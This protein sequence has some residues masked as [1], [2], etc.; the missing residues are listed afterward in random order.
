MKQLATEDSERSTAVRGLYG[1]ADN[2]RR[3][4]HQAVPRNHRVQQF[5][6]N[7]IGDWY[8]SSLATVAA[9]RRSEKTRWTAS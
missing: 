9:F 4:L 1:L 5:D 7:D 6:S 8:L 3:E 2:H